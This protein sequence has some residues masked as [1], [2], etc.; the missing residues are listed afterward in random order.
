[1]QEALTNA[2]RHAPGEPVAVGVASGPGGALVVEVRNPLVP[3]T[4]R[5]APDAPGRERRGLAG[6]RE[7]AHLLRG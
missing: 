1:M 4:R 5:R 6:M 3:G 2:L 7:R